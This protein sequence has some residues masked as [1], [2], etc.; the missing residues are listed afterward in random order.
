MSRNHTQKPLTQ[1]RVERKI[2]TLGGGGRG[3]DRDRSLNLNTTD[4]GTGGSGFECAFGRVEVVTSF[5]SSL[6]GT[7]GA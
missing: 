1:R 3:F 6:G 7:G 2:D 4:R 5:A